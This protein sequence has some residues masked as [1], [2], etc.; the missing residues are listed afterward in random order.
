MDKKIRSARVSVELPPWAALVLEGAQDAYAS[1][2]ER[3]AFAVSLSRK[4]IEEGT[5]GPFAAAVF[6]A[7][8]GRLIAAGVNLVTSLRISCAHA[9][10]VALTQAQAILGNFDLG[11]ESMPRCELVTTTEPCAMCL[12]AIPWSGI[13]SLVCGAR[14]EDAR[15]AGFDE[16]SKRED[17]VKELEAR[18]IAVARDVLREEAAAVLKDYALGGGTLYNGRG[19]R[20]GGRG[21]G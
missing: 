15:A 20:D 14:D 8:T 19:R 6:D 12:G 17:W 1:R 5:G 11:G 16:G 18:G 7:D 2:E 4:N 9:E 10:V 13:R 3:M 21:R